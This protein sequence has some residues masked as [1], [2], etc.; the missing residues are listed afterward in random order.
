MPSDQNITPEQA[1]RRILR[2]LGK[3]GAHRKRVKL[4]FG[5]VLLVSVALAAA[6]LCWALD[7]LFFLSAP[8]R[9]VFLALGA[10][11]LLFVLIGFILIPLMIG[12]SREKLA[13]LADA[14]YPRMRN[15]L[16]AALQLWRKKRDNPEGYS[17][18]LIDAAVVSAERR[19]RDLDLLAVVERSRIRRILR[20]G[21][22][23]LALAVV[24]FLLFPTSLRSSAFRFG[25]PRTSFQQPPRTKLAVTPGSIQVTRHED[26]L[27]RAQIQGKVP[28]QVNISWKE[29]EARWREE[30]CQRKDEREFG[31]LFADVKREI[32]YQVAAGDARSPQYQITVIDRPQVV[33]LR[34]RYRYPAYTHLE[35]RVIEEDGNISAVVGTQVRLE[36]EVNKE[37][38]EAWLS[39]SGDKR[40]E[41]ALTGR[42]AEG[43]LVVEETGTYSI[44]LKDGVGNQNQDP[45]RYRIEAVADEPPLVQITFPGESVDL[46]EDMELPLSL[47]AQDDFGLSRVLLVYQKIRQGE[48]FPEEQ[49]ALP[50]PEPDMPRIEMDHLWNLVSLNLIPE[51]LVAYH[52]VVWDND[53]ISGPKRAQSKTYTVRFPSIHEI[54]A[55]VQEEQSLQIVDLEEILEEEQ[56]LKERLDQIRREL[57]TEDQMTWEQKKDVETALEQQQEI[58][59]ELAQMAEDMDQTL[60][61]IQEKRLAS[62]EI[63][64]KMDQVR[65]LMEEVATPEMQKIM[66]ELQ[67]A[68]QELDPEWVK[69]QMDQFSLT[70]EEL[71][72]RLDRTLSILKRLQAEQRLDALVKRTE[73]MLERQERILEESKE[74]SED[75]LLELAQDQ[76]GLRE[77]VE[78][79][80]DEMQDLSE[81][82][83]Q[84]P[85][86]PSQELA[87]M[88]EELAASELTEQMSQAAQNLS[89]CQQDKAQKSQGLAAQ[90]LDELLQGLQMLQSQM[91]GRMQQEVADAIKKSVQDLLD[92][93][94][95]QENHRSLVQKLD[96]ASPAFGR[97]AEG[98]L[99]LM[100]AASQVSQ[101]IYAVAQKTFFITPEVGKALGE[102]LSRMG[103]A[104]QG[105][106]GRD[107][108]GAAHWEKG[109]MV[110]LNE[111]ARQMLLALDAM[112]ASCSASGLESMMQR[113]QGMSQSQ[114]G[115]NQQTMGLNQ[116]GQY[117]MDQRAQMARLAAEQ[118]TIR[119]SVEDLLQEFGNRSEIPGRLDE[120]GEEM[121][122]VVDD[123]ARRQVDQRTIDRQQRILSRLLD[124]Q[125]SVRRRDYTRR[126]RSRPGQVVVRRSPGELADDLGEVQEQLRQDLLRALD[127]EYPKAYEDLI[128][129]YFQA[130]SREQ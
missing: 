20:L 129:A 5:L 117:S 9:Q 116:Q 107:A 44:H 99:S 39:L 67:R 27:V 12:P 126:R 109:A 115:I 95:E 11:I 56:I 83:S 127:E 63:M 81:L 51:D 19:S 79:L 122:K 57:E 26:V 46:G 94:R 28:Q 114:M 121:K 71:L 53:R 84:F 103:Q 86:M 98:Q 65:E 110:A 10:L 105:L 1:Y 125:K 42:R 21:A 54:L 130:L 8:A 101:D 59:R 91:G 78:A 38:A 74:A 111:A 89:A 62:L 108:P 18:I 128:R 66:E 76:Q 104:L 123:L 41:L 22:G 118:E 47:V 37:L 15:G 87:Q 52:V 33:K 45:I 68:L 30:S 31:H 85:E 50:M 92:I 16:V 2:H 96:R 90:M 106:E 82:M 119:R 49:L 72:Q 60:Q 75:E 6:S 23:L 100:E 77:D 34:L 17:P 36:A 13:R 32:L 43:Q 48:Q 35:S 4:I 58:A 102:A 55:Q 113:L 25:H 24:L 64:E 97:L 93:S 70:Q 73:E 112:G 7:A 120:L 88:A 80:P 14:H 61:R 40:Q 69:Q 124:A 3:L 29:G